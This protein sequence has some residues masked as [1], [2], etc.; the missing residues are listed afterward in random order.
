MVS[1]VTGLQA[2]VSTSQYLKPPGNA[3]VH[4]DFALQSLLVLQCLK[5]V[6]PQFDGMQTRPGAQSSVCIVVPCE[7]GWQLWPTVRTSPGAGGLHVSAPVPAV[8]EATEHFS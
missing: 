1:A 5:H 8:N 7:A 3:R 4:D 2:D 6:F